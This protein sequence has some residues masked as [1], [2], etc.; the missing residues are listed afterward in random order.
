MN[1]TATDWALISFAIAGVWIAEALNTAIEF[2]AD[3]AV[4]QVYPLVGKGQGCGGWW[5]AD[6]G[7]CWCDG[8]HARGF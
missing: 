1:L 5:G 8:V 6:C 7:R 4:P 2:L 3:A